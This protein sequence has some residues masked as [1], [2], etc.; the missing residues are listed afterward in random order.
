MRS[1]RQ[2]VAGRSPFAS[3]RFGAMHRSAPMFT[4]VV[5]F[6]GVGCGASPTSS[7]ADATSHEVAPVDASDATSDHTPQ[8]LSPD[9]APSC[10]YLGTLCHDVDPGD[11]P[12]NE[13]HERG[14]RAEPA[15]CAANAA[16]C[17]A[18]C[19]AAHRAR[20][21]GADASRDGSHFH[22]A[23]S[24]GGTSPSTVAC[25]LLGDYCHA[26]DPGRGPLHECHRGAHDGDPGWCAANVARCHALCRH[27]RA[28]DGGLP[29]GA[30]DAGASPA[31]VACALLGAY[32]HA[33]DPG[34]GPI[35]ECHDG[36]HG[37]DPAWCA[38]H[39]VRCY[40]L[41]RAARASDGGT[42]ARHMH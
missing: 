9:G 39:A 21:A 26:V 1:Q 23:M 28:H 35:H 42:D 31:S 16:R 2:S 37:G 11:G 17:Q 25:S 30:V 20:D 18:L 15:W 12:I 29:D 19:E 34:R 36:A 40:E 6:S 5:W 24:D 22:D 14:H 13:C 38:A 10:D 4:A 7:P 41:C 27:A 33:V 3:A 8:D 32:C